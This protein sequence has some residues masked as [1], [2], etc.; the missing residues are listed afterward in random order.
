MKSISVVERKINITI[1]RG[2]HSAKRG[3][4]PIAFVQTAKEFIE[5]QKRELFHFELNTANPYIALMDTKKFGQSDS[6]SS[7]M[8]KT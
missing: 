4:N 6:S 8:S 3:K 1:L 7:S 2:F 5:K